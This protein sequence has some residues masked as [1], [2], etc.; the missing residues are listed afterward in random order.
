VVAA[1]AGILRVG[2]ALPAVCLDEALDELVNVAG[3]G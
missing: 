1:D 3:L 2:G